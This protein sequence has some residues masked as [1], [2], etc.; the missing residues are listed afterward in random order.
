MRAQIPDFRPKKRK[1]PEP[2]EGKG[3]GGRKPLPGKWKRSL[4]LETSF[5]V[6]IEAAAKARGIGRQQFLREAVAALLDLA[7]R[8]ASFCCKPVI[9]FRNPEM[10][11]V[12][13]QEGDV[14]RAQALVAKGQ[15]ASLTDIVREAGLRAA[16][17]TGGG[18]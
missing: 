14:A 7:E 15:A 11:S 13:L 16:R 17:A 10:V 9:Y 18:I 12:I 2:R 3:K 4:R 1:A 6:E 5:L 8:D